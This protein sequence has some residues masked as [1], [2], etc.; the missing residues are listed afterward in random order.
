MN[1]ESVETIGCFD[2]ILDPYNGVT[3]DSKNLPETKEQFELNLEYLVDTLKH[4]RNLIWIYINIE[5]SE[6]IPIATKEGFFFHSCD[7]D[8]ILVVKR[9]KENAI[10][11]T[12]A[13]HTLGVGAVVINDKNEILV[14]KEKIS[15][16]G[17]KLPG[18]HID[19]CEMIS[20]ALEREVLEETGIIAKFESIISLGHFY[21]HQFHKSNLYI[22]CLAKAKSLEINIQDTQEI[23]D[24][25]WIDVN[26]YLQDQSVLDYSKAIILAALEKEN[27]FIKV[28]Q[29][30]L[31]HIK[32]DFE[33]FF[34]KKSKNSV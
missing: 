17:Y 15:N 26:L 5:K 27:G 19:N 20:T 21:P 29:E 31:A 32:K 8:Y 30:V 11:P 28:N 9:L 33:L 13:N 12:A 22:L 23:L 34:P 3:I 10:I 2:A 16:L 25:K 24:A 1:N 4:K 6:F 14:I 7:E 18:G